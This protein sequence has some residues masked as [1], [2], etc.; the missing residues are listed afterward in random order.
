ME[1][2][3]RERF[4]AA[5]K[6]AGVDRVP[7]ASPVQ[8]G[9]IPLME[10]SG[11]WW[12]DAHRDPEKMVKLALAAHEVAG[13]ESVR[14]PFCGSVEAEAIGCEMTGW[15]KDRQPATKTY[16]L[17]DDN[18][19]DKIQIP[20]PQTAARMPVVTEAVKILRD[21]V[22]KTLPVIAAIVS[23][24]EFAVRSRSMERVMKDIV[25]KPDLLRKVLDFAVKVETE[26]GKALIES[27]AQA[28]FLI[29]GSSQFEVLGPQLYE[30]FSMPYTKQLVSSL[31]CSTIL[32][33]CGNST[34]ILDKMAE[35]GATA[36]SID[37]SVN[38][39]EA[40]TILKGRAAI[41]GNVDPTRS[42]FMGTPKEVED[43]AK[44]C[45]EHGTDVLAPG[46]GFSPQ[47]PIGNMKA[48]VSAAHK[49][50]KK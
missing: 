43:E 16:L 35:T 39:G 32:H 12:P 34:K 27:G 31:R 26:Y 44:N 30:K 8:T 38:I 25:A 46:C 33:I 19:I 20:D 29:D 18:M 13:I 28:L 15:D 21:K 48:I 45:I 22:G 11:A 50:R 5:M 24:F 14:V 17:Q 49:Y 9:T 6:L 36:L 4:E 1:M 42:L 47:T 2:N 10:T 7:A 37:H 41:V 40:K 23:P 3:P